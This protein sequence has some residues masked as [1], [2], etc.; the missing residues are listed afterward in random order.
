MD[1]AKDIVLVTPNVFR[2]EAKN[3]LTQSKNESD[4]KLARFQASNIKKR[5]ARKKK[6]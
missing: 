3:I 4:K 5:Q 2:K 1:K 6:R